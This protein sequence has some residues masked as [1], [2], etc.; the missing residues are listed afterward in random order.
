VGAWGRGGAGTRGRGGVGAWGRASGVGTWGRGGWR[1]CWAI[2]RV[3]RPQL[4]AAAPAL[5]CARGPGAWRSLQQ[6]LARAASNAMSPITPL[7]TPPQMS[8]GALT[9]ALQQLAAGD[10]SEGGDD[11]EGRFSDTDSLWGAGG[12]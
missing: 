3:S 10:S 4:R 1:G 8:A 2:V 5:P 7:L 6:A 11:D 9:A 12:G